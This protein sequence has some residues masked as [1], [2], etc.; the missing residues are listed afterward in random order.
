MALEDVELPKQYRNGRVLYEQNL[1]AWRLATQE[2]FANSNL[3]LQQLARDLFQTGYDF[4]NDGLANKTLS[5]EDRINLLAAGGAPISG[6]SSSTWSYNTSGNTATLAASLLT[7][8]RTYNV[9][10][11]SGTFLLN[12]GAQSVGNLALTQQVY[13]TGS[14]N[15]LNLIGGAHTT[16]TLSTE[17]SDVIL[18]LARTVQ[19]ATGALTNQRAVKILAPTYGFVGASVISNA[20]TVYISGAPIAGTNCTITNNFALWVDSGNVQF[21]GGLAIGQAARAGYVDKGTTSGAVTIDWSAGNTQKVKMDGNVTFT[22]SNPGSFQ[23]MTLI[24]LQ[25]A[26]GSRTVTWPTTVRWVNATGA[27]DSTTDKPTLTTTPNKFDIITFY[28]DSDLSLYIGSFTGSK[29]AIT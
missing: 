29:G 8:G 26:T 18:N 24:L 17:A 20:A 9:P 2:G 4:D 23:K 16:L 22:F 5:L 28:Y 6:T 27:T 19:F 1:D 14:P 13:A 7:S 21:D 12:D 10:D 3:N 25:D 15:I 11:L